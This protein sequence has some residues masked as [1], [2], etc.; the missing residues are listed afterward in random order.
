M[1]STIRR[2]A[3]WY[4]A[5]CNGDWEHD[6]GVQI[7]TRDNPGWSVRISIRGTAVGD[8]DFAELKELIDE[9]GWIH[10]RVVDGHFEG[11]GG[12]LE[13]E[14]ILVVFLLWAEAHV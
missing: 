12:P 4:R 3:T 6:D 9:V 7:D 10:C 13:L 1:D 8:A 5:Q 11:F 14:R 2:L